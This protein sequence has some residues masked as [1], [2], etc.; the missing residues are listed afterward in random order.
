MP[1]IT[2]ATFKKF[3]NTHRDHLLIKNLNNFDGMVDGV[4]DCQNKS[5]RNATTTTPNEHNLGIN[6]IWLVTQSR[7]YFNHYSKDGLTGIEVT[8]CCGNFV[9]AIPE[10]N[11][12]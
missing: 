10:N 7:D 1:K 9:V 3:V 4:R 12:K 2:L 11:S 5:F 8:N 6:G